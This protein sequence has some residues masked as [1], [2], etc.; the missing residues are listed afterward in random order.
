MTNIELP[1]VWTPE[2]I[3]EWVD[4]TIN[5]YFLGYQQDEAAQRVSFR[6][7]CSN[8]QWAKRSDVYTHYLHRYPA[9]LLPYIPIFFLS[10]SL[11]G[12]APILDP[13]A[14]TGTVAVESIV[15]Y[16]N[17]RACNLVEISPLAR[18]ISSAK[19][20]PINPE[21]L[22]KQATRLF[23]ILR[24][25]KDSDAIIP[26]FPGVDLWFRKKAQTDLGMIRFAIE[27]LDADL[28][29]NDFFWVCFSSI[30][31]DM[32]R[33]DPKI[34]PPVLLSS[35]KYHGT[36]KE[37]VS[38]NL[39]R[40]SGY[41]ASVLFRKAVKRNIERMNLIWVVWQ[42]S[43]KC[44]KVVGHDAR[45]LT[46]S[47]YLGKG[48]LDISNET[49]MADESVG[50]VI[51]SPPY[52]NAQKYTRT[53]KFEL[54]WVGLLDP[55]SKA[56]SKY[57]NKLIGTEKI[58]FEEYSNIISVEN[59][60]ADNFIDAVFTIDKQKAGIISKYFRD[61]RTSLKEI[62]RVLIPNGYCALV[63]GNNIVY[64]QQIPNNQILAEI[65]KEEGFVVKAMLVDE[66]RSRG[67]ITKRHDTAGIIADEWVILLQKPGVKN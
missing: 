56:L 38:A 16:T 64:K 13:F 33:A 24:E 3:T 2:A 50:M 58:G 32:S 28:T 15:H 1:S 48:M 42:N 43:K 35:D 4:G 51:T 44:A 54:W 8:W 39:K 6:G 10:S 57:D 11:P 23:K 5:N 45:S 22:K 19:I 46:Q 29:V 18:L 26:E 7:L 9:K 20:T 21:I 47:S 27:H 49:P 31:R 55:D 66:I 59:K 17:P 62:K 53:T 67:L 25:C 60:T 61:M 40:K 12:D 30:I 65:A 63:I 52:I 36:Y 34:S 37:I 14:G 41:T